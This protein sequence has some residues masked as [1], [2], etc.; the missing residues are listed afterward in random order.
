MSRADSG[1]EVIVTHPDPDDLW[2]I[3]VDFGEEGHTH[4]DEYYN[5]EVKAAYKEKSV[6][7]Q[8]FD[9]KDLDL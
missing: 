2:D 4:E 3:D 7:Q 5:S 1:P 6:K 9:I 8:L